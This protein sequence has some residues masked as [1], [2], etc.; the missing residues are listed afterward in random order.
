VSLARSSSVTVLLGDVGELAAMVESDDDETVTLVLTTRPDGRL[1][2]VGDGRATLEYTTPTGIHRVSG[3]LTHDPAQPEI[4]KVRRDG[5]GRTIQR[6][7]HV[8]VEAVVPIEVAVVGDDARRA[9]TTTRN[10]SA[11]GVLIVEP[12]RLEIG[13]AVQ[14]TLELD[15]ASPPLVVRGTVVRQAAPG[16]RGIHFDG[17]SRLDDQRLLRFITERERIALRIRQGR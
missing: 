17:L 8:R 11:R 15:P 3:D 7:D 6:R 5:R 1:A 14:L 4:L 13:E 10:V 16:E 2:R 12:F 9:E